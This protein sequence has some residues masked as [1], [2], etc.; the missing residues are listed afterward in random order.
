MSSSGSR[1]NKRATLFYLFSAVAKLLVSARG[2]GHRVAER[3]FVD[4]FHTLPGPSID[5]LKTLLD[6]L[7]LDFE[8]HLTTKI[9]DVNRTLTVLTAEVCHSVAVGNV[10]DLLFQWATCNQA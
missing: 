9:F 10:P 3:F 2:R 7:P 4:Q 1:L 5:T 8:R 6:N